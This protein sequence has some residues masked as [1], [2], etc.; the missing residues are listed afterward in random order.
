MKA[1]N[2]SCLRN[3]L[4]LSIAMGGMARA[5]HITLINGK[6]IDGEITAEDVRTVTIR[7][8]DSTSNI[9]FSR[10]LSKSEIKEISRPKHDGPAYVLLP[11]HGEIGKDVTVASVQAGLEA[12]EK[13]GPKY[14][15]LDINSPGG[16]IG[17]MFGIMEAIS[18]AQHER[19]IV[20]YVQNAYSA[21]AVIA[22]SCPK[23]YIEPH[24][25]IGAAVPFKL[26]ENGPVDVEA[27]FR[28]A[29]E[30]K[31]RA[32]VSA[33]G[34]DPLI[35]RGMM[36][37][38]AEIYLT[39]EG[40]HPVLH[41]SGPDGKEIKGKGS[42]LTLTA[43]E[44]AECGLAPLATDLT[45]VGK[46]LAGGPWYEASHL[47]WDAAMAAATTQQREMRQIESVRAQNKSIAQAR[48]ELVE[49]KKRM[50]ELADAISM[51][52][53]LAHELKS[54]LQGDMRQVEA[55][56]ESA[57]AQSRSSD[58]TQ[59]ANSDREQHLAQLK[60]H[61]NDTLGKLQKEA[62]AASREMKQLHD[63][64]KEIVASLPQD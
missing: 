27:K 52:I 58:D 20:A 22:M 54:K 39:T 49:I 8:S 33:A 51:D 2:I 26:T 28:S 10:R 30:A 61:F 15:V 1:L 25:V 6:Q 48:P 4:M 46:Q 32:Y 12:A 64:E 50:R 23:I 29:L 7:I 36:D 17:A 11:I 43:T 31:Q 21:A 53:S 13:V 57:I 40:G 56:Y 62:N 42:I 9:A 3:V 24:G 14:V 41:D 38:D 45:D 16:N 19:P 5:D 47:P 35:L 34:H 37:M 44:A 18:K 55:E 63:R 59:R 60:E